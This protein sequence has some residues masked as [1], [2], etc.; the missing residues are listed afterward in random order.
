VGLRAEFNYPDDS[1]VV[2]KGVVV[3][4]DC[5]KPLSRDWGEGV[6][7]FCYRGRC[8]LET[9]CAALCGRHV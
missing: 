7:K 5:V 2:Q 8:M 4:C 3:F 9:V 1:G 6:G